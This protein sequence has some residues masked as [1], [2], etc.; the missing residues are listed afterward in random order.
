MNWR[1]RTAWPSTMQLIQFPAHAAI[2]AVIPT[3]IT[4]HRKEGQASNADYWQCIEIAD[5][6]SLDPTGK[7]LT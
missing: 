3:A 6:S 5:A 4:T 7:M 2:T 1:L